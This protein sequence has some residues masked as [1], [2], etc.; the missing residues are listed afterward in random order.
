MDE[1]IDVSADSGTDSSA[2]D[3][4]NVEPIV[5]IPVEES[6]MDLNEAEPPLSEPELAELQN[7]AAAL[8]IEPLAE[9]SNSDYFEIK[10]ENSHSLGERIAAG[11]LA[12]GMPF[13]YGIKTAAE[14][15]NMEPFGAPTEIRMEM[16]PDAKTPGQEVEAF[17]QEYGGQPDVSKPNPL[18]TADELAGIYM[19]VAEL[20]G[21]KLG[22]N[23]DGGEQ[24][25]AP[26]KP[27]YEESSDIE[28]KG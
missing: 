2:T 17:L 8:E 24:N 11:M 21:T 19:D 18:Q 3:S 9:E 16:P 27:E 12:A 25:T 22:G 1:D 23:L 7:E 5:D 26:C 15:Q 6:A 10:G 4:I 28:D 13:A 14:T 20:V